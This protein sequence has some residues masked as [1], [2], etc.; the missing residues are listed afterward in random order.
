MIF[1][2]HRQADSEAASQLY[3]TLQGKGISA[4]LDV[5]DPSVKT[6]DEIT[7]HI[8]SMLNRCTHV[9]VVFSTNTVGSMWVPFELGAAYQTNKGIGTWLISN[10]V[11]LPEYLKAFPIMRSFTDL[12]AYLTEYQSGTVKTAGARGFIKAVEKRMKSY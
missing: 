9:I 11:S 10:T 2:S 12:G 4:W 6:S 5:L 7:D 1:I 8:I 3:K